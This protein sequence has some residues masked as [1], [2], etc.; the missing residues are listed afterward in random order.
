[1][2]WIYF[3]YAF[4]AW[5]IAILISLETYSS[6]QVGVNRW[7]SYKNYI[8]NYHLYVLTSLI[9]MIILVNLIN[10]GGLEYILQMFWNISIINE[11]IDITVI[12]RIFCVIFGLNIE[13]V[14]NI[15]RRWKRPI[16]IEK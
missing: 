11:K 9:F 8:Y 12:N 1:M 2:F 4:L 16:T 5:L 13:F 3:V 15:F 7:Q 6:A 14:L 10:M